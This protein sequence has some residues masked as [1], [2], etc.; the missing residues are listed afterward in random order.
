MVEENLVP[1]PGRGELTANYFQNE[2]E[3]KEYDRHRDE[4]NSFTVVSDEKK[5]WQLSQQPSSFKE[6]KRK[7]EAQQVLGDQKGE[8]SDNF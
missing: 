6:W 2:T 8:A 4:E 5:T 3:E 1:F 7:K